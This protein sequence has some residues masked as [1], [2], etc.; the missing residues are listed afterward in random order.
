MF[1]SGFSCN[2]LFIFNLKKE[3][4]S[5]YSLLFKLFLQVALNEEYFSKNVTRFILRLTEIVLIYI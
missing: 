2:I 4:K 3:E 1:S 5:K